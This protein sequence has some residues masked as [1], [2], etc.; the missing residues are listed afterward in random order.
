MKEYYPTPFEILS[1]LDTECVLVGS[2]ARK[3][4]GACKDVDFVVSDKGMNILSRWDY[5]LDVISPDWKVWIPCETRF[6]KAID[7]FHGK[8][9]IEDRNKWKDRLTYQEAIERPLKVVSISDVEVLSL[10][11]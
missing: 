3:Y 6:N 9:D 11:A 1:A 2:C 7:F 8:C 10:T 5:Y 4:F